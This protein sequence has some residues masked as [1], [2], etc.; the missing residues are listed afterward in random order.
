M[1]V[2]RALAP[3]SRNYFISICVGGQPREL[4]KCYMTYIK[5]KQEEAE[6][7]DGR[8]CAPTPSEINVRT[9][10]GMVDKKSCPT[11]SFLNLEMPS[12]GIVYP[13][14]ETLWLLTPA[15]EHQ[16]SCGAKV[17]DIALQGEGELI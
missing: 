11:E 2:Y 9:G 17:F 5:R 7:G 10:W 15:W 3:L 6:A 8:F 1:T 12:R 14:G 16:A 4:T 13:W